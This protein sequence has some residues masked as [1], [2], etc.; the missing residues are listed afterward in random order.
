MPTLVSWKCFRSCRG[1]EKLAIKTS[2]F[3][4][5]RSSLRERLLL[6]PQPTFLP[7]FLPLS[8]SAPPVSWVACKDD[9]SVC[10]HSVPPSVP[11]ECT[12]VGWLVGVSPPDSNA[13]PSSTFSPEEEREC[14]NTQQDE[15]KFPFLRW[16]DTSNPR[17]FK[18]IFCA[19][20]PLPAYSRG[21]MRC[22]HHQRWSKNRFSLPKQRYE[23]H[24]I[25]LEFRPID[26][27]PQ[28][29]RGFSVNKVAGSLLNLSS[30]FYRVPICNF[31]S[32]ER[33]EAKPS[34]SS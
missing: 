3:A 8:T 11:T 5:Q 34:L 28:W 10:P 9:S 33:K 27:R 26:D 1:R 13:D 14:K 24:P 17:L 22:P 21:S 16:H 32:L 23:I 7:F 29:L 25:L 6:P 30:T 2:L 4:S 12:M 15:E 19:F 20:L 18:F 31:L